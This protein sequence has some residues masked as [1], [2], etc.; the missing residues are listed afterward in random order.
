MMQQLEIDNGAWGSAGVESADDGL[1]TLIFIWKC[2][3]AVDGQ[4]EERRDSQTKV[5]D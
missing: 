1:K 3:A 4:A 5:E 2:K